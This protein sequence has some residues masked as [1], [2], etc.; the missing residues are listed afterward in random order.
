MNAENISP[1]DGESQEAGTQ[2]EQTG[3]ES[4]GAL[5]AADDS[6]EPGDK[7][8]GDAEKTKPT[9]FNDLAGTLDMDLDALYKLEIASSEDGE[10]ITIEQLKDQHSKAVDFELTQ[11]EHEERRIQQEQD[12]TRAQSELQ[13]ILQALPQNAVKPEV[14]QKIR[15]RS[16]ATTTLE[17]QKTLVAI[18]EWKDAD[19]RQADVAA[20]TEHL[21]GYGYPVGYLGNVVDHRQLKYIRDNWQREERMRKAL[22]AVR[23]GKP[24]KSAANKSQKTAPKKGSLSS[25][26]VPKGESK[27]KAAFSNL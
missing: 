24:A 1:S 17:R 11:L 7:S 9:K 2:E 15:E 12:L 25:I 20:M 14:L 4:L 3:L 19:T 8:S 27:L 22:E 26:K 23:A 21:Q 16:N 18:P 10:S 13:E 6:G 5:L